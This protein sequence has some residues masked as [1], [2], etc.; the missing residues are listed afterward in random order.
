[1]KKIK[2]KL[3][4][5]LL[6]F[7]MIVGSTI[8]PMFA[9]E[10]NTSV[11]DPAAKAGTTEKVNDK[12]YYHSQNDSKYIFEK[13]S[14]PNRG[15]GEADG[16]L[17]EEDSRSQSYAWAA[18]ESGDYI[19]VGTCF[20]STYGIYYR[21]V[22]QMMVKAGK[23]QAEAAKIA[24]DFVQFVFND[25]FDENLKVRGIVI[26]FHKQTGEFSLVYDSKTDID[27]AIQQTS[28]SGY[29]M[30]FEFNKKLYFVSLAN[31]TMF[32]LEIDPNNNDQS[33]IAFKRSLSAQGQAAQIASGVHGLI[34]YDDE[35][36]MCLADEASDENKWLDGKPH[37]EGGMIVASKDARNWRVIGDE[38]DLGPSAYHNYDGLMGG[39]IWDIIEYN[40][41]IYTTV[42]T[43]LT[44]PVTGKVNKQGFAMYRGTKKSNGDFEWKM[45][46]GNTSLDGVTYP[47]GLGTNYAMACNLWVYDNHLYMGTYNDP[48]LDLAEVPARAN[49]EPLYY[50]LYYSVNLYRMD[51][52][53]NIELVAGKSNDV[54]KK[55]IGNMGAGLGD[56]SNQYIWRM[57]NHDDKLWVA[58]YDTSTLTSVFTQLTDGQLVGMSKE[59]YQKRLNQLKILATS[60]SVLKEENEKVFDII[61][62]S[63]TMRKL[64]DS[65]QK[66]I[67]NGVGNEDPVPKYLEMVNSYNQFKDK[68]TNAK[69]PSYLQSLYNKVLEAMNKTTLKAMDKIIEEMKGPVY[70]FG[71]NHYMKKSTKG[72]DLLVSEDGINFEVVTN[73]GFGDPSNHGV[74]TL[75]SA[76]NNET[77]FVGTANPYYGG[78]IWKT[79]DNIPSD[80]PEDIPQAPSKDDITALNIPVEVICLSNEEHQISSILS[81]KNTTTGLVSKNESGQYEVVIT[82]DGSSYIKKFNNKFN[83][84]ENG[85]EH[86]L[87]NEISTTLV[88]TWNKDSK[89]WNVASDT[90]VIYQM[91]EMP[92][93]DIKNYKV[94]FNAGENGTFNEGIENQFIITSGNSIGTKIPKVEVQTGYEFIGWKNLETEIIYTNEQVSKL[95]VTKDIN[96]VAMY[97]KD[98]DSW[99]SVEFVSGA[100]GKFAENSTTVHVVLKNSQII[101][102]PEVI[103]NPDYEFIGWKVQNDDKVYSSTDI[104]KMTF[105]VDTVITA[106]YHKNI[107]EP[108]MPIKYFTVQF[109][110]G[111]HGKAMGALSYTIAEGQTLTTT[112]AINP[113]DGY[114][115]IG[116]SYKGNIYTSETVK[117]VPVTGDMIFV[118][119]YKENKKDIGK[120]DTG[121]NSITTLWTYTGIILSGVFIVFILKKKNGHSSKDVTS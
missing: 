97:R 13:V 117:T 95:V 72:F 120:V 33:T 98:K 61:F 110:P 50:D 44:D 115:F 8:S 94:S 74:R 80:I 46:I 66:F 2:E 89:M 85:I 58:T 100:D 23:T 63:K 77:L 55:A 47:Y 42:V 88:L 102:I 25:R 35:I 27:P 104:L 70:Y 31:P 82:V 65:I 9:I 14:H 75:T 28:C 93:E 81:G 39:G 103:P 90:K 4:C 45:M 32:L 68:I 7:V 99:I 71:T 87:D 91:S 121:D 17:D 67:D 51:E 5:V 116:W 43:D 1:M 56:N 41:H 83:D 38:D 20:N 76:D 62:G 101:S 34:V 37:P 57:V 107:S 12:W 112:P 92:I 11:D 118:A 111:K 84:K 109:E 59:E 114:E 40:G 119:K 108:P 113:D 48:M 36:L 3:L 105:A 69:V 6:S 21:N 79:V 106:V 18:V 52:K 54:F 19:Y 10:K 78:Q 30:A 16:F 64:F 53:E 49:F 29:R 73:D 26:K 96:F 86:K 15:A 60:L 24:R 22:Y